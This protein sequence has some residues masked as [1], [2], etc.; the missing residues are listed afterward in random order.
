MSADIVPIGPVYICDPEHPHFGEGGVLTG[1][2]IR[3][4]DKP[5]AEVSLVNCK[6]G[7]GGC[8]VSH[9]QIARDKRAKRG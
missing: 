1:K 4:F 7:T 9:G 8:F 5:M 6:H 3:L 2:V